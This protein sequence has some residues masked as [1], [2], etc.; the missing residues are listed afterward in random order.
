MKPLIKYIIIT[1]KRDWLFLGLFILII[2]ASFVSLFLGSTSLSEQNLMQVAYLSG[3][4]RLILVLG[5]TFFICFHIRRSFD[6]REIEFYLSKS[7]SRTK[8][9]FAYFLG[10]GILGIIITIPVILSLFIFF[11]IKFFIAALW[12]LSLLFEILIMS[13]FAILASL[14]LSSAIASVFACISF[15]F[16][17]RIIGLA[18]STIIIPNQLTNI[19][20]QGLLELTLKFISIFLPRLDLFAKSKWLVYQTI[21]LEIFQLILIQ[22][23]IYIGIIFVM[24]L[25]DFSKKQF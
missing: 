25:I 17:S 2:L 11:N 9:I 13:S 12:S 19:N 24:S 1:A 6:N 14:I 4:T 7:L 23:F 5:M 15:Y 3:S 10:F 20:F 21:S 8:F 18:V 16:I 22:T